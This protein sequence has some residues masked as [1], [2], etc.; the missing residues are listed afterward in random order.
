MVFKKKR[1]W[2]EPL[3][4]AE[5]RRHNGQNVFNWKYLKMYCW[6]WRMFL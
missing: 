1:S 5:T 3:I 2:L 4:K 6:R